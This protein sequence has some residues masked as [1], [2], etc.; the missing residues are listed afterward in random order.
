[1]P[2]A[3]I[4]ASA[5]ALALLGMNG[6]VTAVATP[7]EPAIFDTG[8]S[9]SLTISRTPDDDCSLVSKRGDLCVWDYND[10]WVI[11]DCFDP[12]SPSCPT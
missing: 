5:S 2:I 12:P 1:M 11:G 6:A 10:E 7:S 3:K 9:S 4:I 8:H